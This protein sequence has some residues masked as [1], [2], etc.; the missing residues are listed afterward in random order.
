MDENPPIFNNIE[1]LTFC[2]GHKLFSFDFS[3]N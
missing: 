3:K 1:F 2:V